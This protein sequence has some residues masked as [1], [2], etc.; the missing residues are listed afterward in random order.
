MW[1]NLL[2]YLEIRFVLVK[3]LAL[4]KHYR[5]VLTSHNSRLFNVF[6]ER[7]ALCKRLQRSDIPARVPIIPFLRQLEY[8]VA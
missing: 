4:N 2:R 5:N 8:N 3:L 6:L 1:A 7:Y